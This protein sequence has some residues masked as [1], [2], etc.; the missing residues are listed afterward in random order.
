MTRDEVDLCWSDSSKSAIDV[1]VGERLRLRR[2]DVGL[3]ST[4]M[5]MKPGTS[6]DDDAMRVGSLPRSMRWWPFRLVVLAILVT[7]IAN[8][9]GVASRFK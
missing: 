1:Q 5:S 2:E 3:N 4:E 6:Y 7:P 9:A 8:G